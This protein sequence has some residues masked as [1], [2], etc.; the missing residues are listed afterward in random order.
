[1]ASILIKLDTRRAN[2]E[3]NFPVKVVIFNNQTNAAISISFSVPES[4]WVKDG[5]QRPVKSSYPGA[6]MINDRIEKFYLDVRQKV[7]E[8]EGSGS[9]QNMKAADIKK[10]ILAGNRPVD[11]VTFYSFAESFVEGCRAERTRGVYRHTL[12]KLKEY[13]KDLSFGDITSS[14]LRNFDSHLEKTGSGVN[15]RS[16]HFRNI[17]A[18][19]NR[20]IDDEVIEP[21]VYPFRKFKIRSERKNRECLTAE[22]V[23]ALYDYRFRTDSL[24]MARDYWMLS[25]FLCGIS[26]VDLFHLKKPD[27]N[28]RIAFVRQKERNESHEVIR[29]FIQ[30]EAAVI[31][32]RYGADSDSG[33]LLNFE[34]KYVSYDSFKHFISK[35]IREIAE[36]TGF[37]GLTLY[38][39]R[40]SWATI[41]D[42]T[43]IQEKIISKGL[44][45]VDKTIAG[46]HYIAFDWTRVDTANR[47]VI[48]YVL[49]FKA[50]G[51]PQF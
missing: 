27:G 38:W 17:R 47:A 30:P 51:T 45:H 20:A 7:L 41:A 4:A 48:D 22:Q 42:S 2:A 3:G 11:D 13:V 18:I 49:H 34:S 14:F 35:K 23:K 8:L 25:F 44:G 37:E 32:D 40:Y 19:F 6:K 46:R 50:D 1:M 16:I 5:L 39:A 26:P 24:N 12:S 29:L 9:I 15:T 43:G 31:I 21:N 28:N 36:I 33:Y 10:H